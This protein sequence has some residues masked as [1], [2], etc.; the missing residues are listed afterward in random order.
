MEGQTIVMSSPLTPFEEK[1]ARVAGRE[2][3]GG[4][5]QE[6]RLDTGAEA[7]G[8]GGQAAGVKGSVS[9]LRVRAERNLFISEPSAFCA[10]V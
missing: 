7:A 6:V 2:C 10:F 3:A 1:D 9:S 4:R 8:R 5:G